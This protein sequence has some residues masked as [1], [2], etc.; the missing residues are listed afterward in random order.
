ME[1]RHI[2]VPLVSKIFSQINNN[3]SI[4][5]SKDYWKFGRVQS[6]NLCRIDSAD[7]NELLFF[8]VPT[9]LKQ[10]QI[11]TED[12]NKAV[13]TCDNNNTKYLSN[14]PVEANDDKVNSVGGINVNGQTEKKKICMMCELL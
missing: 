8:R 9:L 12:T 6:Q 3:N 7:F 14:A 2:V 10:M 13:N 11:R 1:A 4:S 5:K